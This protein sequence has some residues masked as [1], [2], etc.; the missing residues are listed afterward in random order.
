MQ[1]GCIIN[2]EPITLLDIIV[3]KEGKFYMTPTCVGIAYAY[4]G[5]MGNE[6][7]DLGELLHEL[8]KAS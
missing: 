6:V 2:N 4:I 1:S 8:S 3:S 5:H 7:R